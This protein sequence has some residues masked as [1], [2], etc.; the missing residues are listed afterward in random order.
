MAVTR[1]AGEAFPLY[2]SLFNYRVGKVCFFL[3]FPIVKSKD[4]AHN[5][6]ISSN[7]CFKKSKD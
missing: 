5:L 4:I 1:R 7:I 2:A 6:L 3:Q